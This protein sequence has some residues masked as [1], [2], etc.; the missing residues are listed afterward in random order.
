MNTN[1][2]RATVKRFQTIKAKLVSAMVLILIVT[3]SISLTHL[4]QAGSDAREAGHYGLIN[5]AAGALN[6][7]AGHQ[8]LERGYGALI[9]Q[10]DKPS[11]EL[12][13]KFQLAG[14][15]GDE[16]LAMADEP[17]GKLI[18]SAG[19]GDLGELVDK[20]KKTRGRL[21]EARAA[22][23]LRKIGL[24]EWTSTASGNIL[25]EFNV[26]DLAFAPANEKE[27]LRHYNTIIRASAATLAEYAG[28]ERAGLFEALEKG[29]PISDD[30]T[31][32]LGQYRTI[33]EE[34]SGRIM[35]V[36]DLSTTP[37][38]LK[39]ALAIYE[40]EFL[41]AYG[42][43]R[44]DIYRKSRERNA[45]IAGLKAAI[46]SDK[47]RIESHMKSRTE[48]LVNLA[49]SANL[50]KL[51]RA[52]GEG[53][54]MAGLRAAAE[55]D[56]Y[57]LSQSTREYLR[58]GF[59]DLKGKEIVRVDFTGAS[60]VRVSGERLKT[61]GE[62]ILAEA[63]KLGRGGIWVSSMALNM[64][65]GKVETPHRP[66]ISMAVPAV[67]NNAP[68]G[69]IIAQVL[70]SG[71]L[72]RLAKAGSGED[73]YLMDNNGYYLKHPNEA[74]QWGFTAG[75]DRHKSNLLLDN[76][77]IAEGVLSRE[78]GKKASSRGE[79]FVWSPVYYYPGKTDAYWTL[80]R[81]L[82]PV[83]Y[84]MS[85]AEWMERATKAIGEVLEI[86]R[87]VGDLS[88]SVVARI[89]SQSRRAIIGNAAA[90]LFSA[91]LV[92]GAIALVI[93]SVINPLAGAVA[94]LRDIS[95]GEGDLTLRME[96]KS[97]D[98][99]GD[100]AFWF[101]KF[102]EKIQHVLVEISYSSKTLA[103]S[104]HEMAGVSRQ[105]ATGSEQMTDKANAVAGSTEQMS[106]TIGA[107]ASAVEQM[108]MNISSVSTG[109]E[110][111]S[112]SMT[113]VARNVEEMNGSIQKIA[114]SSRKALS[115]TD[116]AKERSAAASRVMNTLGA[117]AQE[118]GKVTGV[119]KRIAEQT[120]LLALNATIEAASAGAAGKGFAVVAHE[121]KQLASQSAA[122]AED[123]AV[124]IE[125]VQSNTEKAVETIGE[126][127]SAINAAGT[128]VEDIAHSVEAQ[129][130][131][132]G[133]ISATVGQAAA[134]AG[135]I[136][137][138]IAEIAKG[139][140]EVSGSVGEAAQGAMEVSS[141]IQVV[142]DSAADT[143]AGAQMVNNSSLGLAR[144]AGELDAMIS[145]FKVA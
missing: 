91:A 4:I 132:S 21:R 66:V 123:I 85:G 15:K 35:A 134:G 54:D 29:A 47:A 81:A 13:A 1:V 133:E 107:M 120:N 70:G 39:T 26:R 34:A 65:G 122:A 69:Y 115:V 62:G 46:D 130:R 102:V 101:N 135:S 121:I 30:L 119:I 60:S 142:R 71:L 41:G 114:A 140:G 74:R 45:R 83:D 143:T 96:V 104:S 53:G 144:I 20:W 129:S 99:L 3:I 128:A 79:S 31:S 23:P 11:Q 16:N 28:R 67:V 137:G 7:A 75:L 55:N 108:S 109:A 86:S 92:A 145:R 61:A 90:S 2:G 58:V 5:T 24:E 52:A 89:E 80:A 95:E 110:Q 44:E 22:V 33:M 32:R 98:E 63:R 112:Q 14:Q 103:A 12:T 77:E 105:L 50:V 118:I 97:A 8:A 72:G 76:P 19:G 9:L 43:V 37:P 25:M 6:E 116:S 113:T 64:E 59:V 78:P 36:K 84:G 127:F 27:Q 68:A 42:E 111:M 87:V 88:A 56:F 131:A 136:A 94:R 117:A 40:K 126:V 49:A 48:E 73:A 51:A 82:K 139:A 57:A 106:S 17:L 138:S 18:L 124:R 100:L 141:N 38:A 93:F 10:T 125:G